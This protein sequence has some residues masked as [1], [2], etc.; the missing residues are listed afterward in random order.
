MIKGLDIFINHFKGQE[1]KYILIGGAAC[2]IALNDAG[3]AFR[4][5]KDLDI[6]LLIEVLDKEFSAV[7]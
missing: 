1:G 3:L 5:T 2:D 4:A 7:F 6:V